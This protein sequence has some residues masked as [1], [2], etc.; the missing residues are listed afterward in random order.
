MKE[1]KKKSGT[2]EETYNA[3]ESDTGGLNDMGRQRGYET[4]RARIE[5]RK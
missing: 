5:K 4:R 3:S 1:K 2:M